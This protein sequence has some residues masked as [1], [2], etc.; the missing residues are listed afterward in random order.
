[1]ACSIRK[2]IRS[3]D[4]EVRKVAVI[5]KERNTKREIKESSLKLRSLLS[6][7]MTNEVQELLQKLGKTTSMSP[8]EVLVSKEKDGDEE[9][10]EKKNKATKNA[11]TQTDSLPQE[12]L[13]KQ[14]KL[15]N[16]F[17]DYRKINHQRWP[18]KVF[19]SSFIVRGSPLQISKDSDALILEEIGEGDQIVEKDGISKAYEKL[20][21]GIADMEGKLSVLTIIT[22]AENRLGESIENSKFVFRAELDNSQED[23]FN[24]LK[25][26]RRRM[27]KARR[28]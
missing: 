18:E 16:S 27:E 20:Y 7:L 6:Q 11:S 25:E 8:E 24:C 1:M 5:A 17:E 14:I 3:L 23:W 19:K 21:P 13:P 9:R 15:T 2:I 28:K 10:E 26:V 22:K 12:D 4:T